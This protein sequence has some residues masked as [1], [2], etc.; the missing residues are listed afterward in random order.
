MIR[1]DAYARV[2]VAG[3]IGIDQEHDVIRE[4]LTDKLSR[5]LHRL[6]GGRP[7]SRLKRASVHNLIPSDDQWTKASPSGTMAV[8]TP[9]SAPDGLGHALV[10][11]TRSAVCLAH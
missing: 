7:Q 10:A 11:T 4:D 6:L 1:I 2:V 8:A 9:T 5:E 3:L